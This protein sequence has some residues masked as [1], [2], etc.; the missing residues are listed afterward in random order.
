MGEKIKKVV[1]TVNGRRGPASLLS[2]VALGVLV[3]CGS[4]DTKSFSDAKQQARAEYSA[5]FHRLPPIVKFEM[6]YTGAPNRIVKIDTGGD[7][8]TTFIF[9]STCLVDSP[10]NPQAGTVQGTFSS[11]RVQGEST[12]SGAFVSTDQNLPDR[13]VIHPSNPLAP[14]LSFDGVVTNDLILVPANVQT[15]NALGP[16]GCRTGITSHSD[17]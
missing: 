8:F 6:Q 2:A 4:A 3:G 17:K 10:W 1:D 9:N 13:L 5:R 14:N 12:P 11:G 16:Y 15:S 7:A